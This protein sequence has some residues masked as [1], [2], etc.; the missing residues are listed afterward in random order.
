MKHWNIDN[1]ERDII[2]YAD[3]FCHWCSIAQVSQSHITM[4]LWWIHDFYWRVF[5]MIAHKKICFD[6]FH[7]N[8]ITLQSVIF[9][10]IYL[11]EYH[12]KGRDTNEKL[13]EKGKKGE[14]RAARVRRSYI[15]LLIGS[16]RLVCHWCVNDSFPFLLSAW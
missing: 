7:F 9:E 2:F 16:L 5:D 10:R 3:P 13:L 15:I 11:T 1:C 14:G 4:D 6:L 12:S 8:S